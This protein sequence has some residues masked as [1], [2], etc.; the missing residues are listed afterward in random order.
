MAG[1]SAASRSTSRRCGDG[2]RVAGLR[3]SMRAHG[4]AGLGLVGVA[5]LLLAAR[6]PTVDGRFTPLPR[7]GYV[8]FLGPLPPRRPGRPCLPTAR[9][10]P[11]PLALPSLG[12]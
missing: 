6:D 3:P 8:L 2:G 5:E 4:W 11:V 9:A 12:R 1:T 10:A 7:A